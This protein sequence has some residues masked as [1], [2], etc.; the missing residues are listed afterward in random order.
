LNAVLE[1]IVG[2]FASLR[3]HALVVSRK[4]GNFWV[5]NGPAMGWTRFDYRPETR[6]VVEDVGNIGNGV[7]LQIR[8]GIYD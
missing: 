6:K 8:R 3:P 1:I 4:W 2:D 7:L 5:R